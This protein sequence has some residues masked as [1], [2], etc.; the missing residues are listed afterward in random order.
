MTAVRAKLAGTSL[1]SRIAYAVARVVVGGFVVL[2]TRMTV[3]GRHHIP[4]SGAF[5]MS[6]VHRSYV[7]TPIAA[8]TTRRRML[9]M[10]KDS[11]WKWR[12]IGWF[13][14]ALGA[15]PVSRGTADR[16]ALSR[17]LEILRRG[18]PIVLFPEGERK[19]GPVVQPLFEGAAYLAGRADVPIIPVGIGGSARVMPRHAKFVFPHKV[20]VVIGAPIRV[21][22]GPNGRAARSSVAAAT[23]RLHTDLQRLFDEAQRRAG[24]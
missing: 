23:E 7:D 5:I 13:V 12:P 3:E 14:S 11:I 17:C 19:D 4:A 8:S 24:C 2:W 22:R 21:E 20:H 10:G 9:Y 6:P 18:E 15:F 1:A 16:E